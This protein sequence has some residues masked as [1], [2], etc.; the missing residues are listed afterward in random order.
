MVVLFLGRALVA[1]VP[2]LKR[3]NCAVSRFPCIPAASRYFGVPAA[4]GPGGPGAQP[5]G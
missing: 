4:P 1:G 5:K 3:L 2:A